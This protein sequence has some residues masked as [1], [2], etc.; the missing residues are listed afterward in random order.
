MRS[1]VDIN[2]LLAELQLA[3]TNEIEQNRS[4]RKQIMALEMELRI[5]NSKLAAVQN[6]IFDD[7]KR[8]HYENS[9]R[10]LY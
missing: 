4:A 9:G 3:L 5:A 2:I 6:K 8:K 7:I 1:Q 10:T